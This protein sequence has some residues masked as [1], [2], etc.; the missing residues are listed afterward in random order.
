MKRGFILF[1]INALLLVA[2]CVFIAERHSLAGGLLLS[3]LLLLI[4]TTR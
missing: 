3:I 4:I 2:G 1:V